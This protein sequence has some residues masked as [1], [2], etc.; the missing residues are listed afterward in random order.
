[1]IA[2]GIGEIRQ[3]IR[4]AVTDVLA[5]QNARDFEARGMARDALQA[6]QSHE[7]LC[8]ERAATAQVYR[9]AMHTG[10]VDLRVSSEKQIDRINRLIQSMLFSFIATLVVMLGVILWQKFF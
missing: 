5:E 4:E 7:R 10:L 2:Q 3:L 6:I 9:E 8:L 1:M